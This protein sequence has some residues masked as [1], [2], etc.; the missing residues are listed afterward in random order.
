ME[1]Q[2][3]KSLAAWLLRTTDVQLTTSY[4]A[5]TGDH[6]V[7]LEILIVRTVA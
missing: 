5:I 1:Q 6:S 4:M 3:H 2:K 7:T